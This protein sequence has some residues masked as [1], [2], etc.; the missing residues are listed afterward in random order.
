MRPIRNQV[1]VRQ[2]SPDEI[3][4]KSGF[5]IPV[6]SGIQDDNRRLKAEVVAVADSVTTIKP[7]EIVE[8]RKW[9]GEDY[10]DM[11]LLD[12]REIIGVWE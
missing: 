4:T 10:K 9:A 1:L 7:G 11:K 6:P 3:K 2:I 5:I 12:V 8:V